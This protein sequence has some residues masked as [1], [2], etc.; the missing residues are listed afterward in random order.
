MTIADD[1]QRAAEIGL[2]H[3]RESFLLCFK[4]MTDGLPKQYR[5]QANEIIHFFENETTPAIWERL[6]QIPDPET[7]QP[8]PATGI[9]D[10][11]KV[12]SVA[13]SWVAQWEQ[14]AQATGKG[15]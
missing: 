1:A 12:R 5:K 14:L 2:E 4:T 3:F 9:V 15:A 6:K 7:M 10:P 8:D 11:T 13:D